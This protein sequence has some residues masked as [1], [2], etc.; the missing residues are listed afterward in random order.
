MAAI[1]TA[2]NPNRQPPDPKNEDPSLDEHD[3]YSLA[4]SHLGE[5]WPCHLSGPSTPDPPPTLGPLLGLLLTLF[6]PVPWTP[7]LI[8]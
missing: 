6:Q 5:A 2:V 8:H 4:Y 3:L 1:P 7:S